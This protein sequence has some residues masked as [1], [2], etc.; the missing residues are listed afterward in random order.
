MIPRYE[1]PEIS[2]LWTEEHK[3]K[4]FLKVEL[5]LLEALES[6]KNINVER[7]NEIEMTTQHDLIA[8]CT[9]ITE[10]CPPEA[11]KYFHYGVTSSDIIDTSLSL[12]LKESIEQILPEY[13]ALQKV[14]WK[15]AN[16]FKKLICMGRSHGMFAE[17]QSFGQKFL[18]SYA[19]FA[20]HLELLKDFYENDCTGQLSGAVGNY[21]ILNTK[22]EEKA[23]K[24]LNLKIEPV[25]TQVIPRDRLAKFISISS[26]I[27]S[28]IERLSGEI[29]HLHHSDVQELHE[30]FSKGQK[31]S[32]TM[33]HKKN[34]ISAENLTGMARL[35]RSHLTIA[36]ENIA[37]W[38]ERDISHSST[39]RMYLPDHLGIL[40][41]SIRRLRKTID[42]LVIHEEAIEKKVA[43][44]FTYLS[45]YFLHH[46]IKNNE[47]MRETFYEIIQQAAFEAKSAQDFSESIVTFDKSKGITVSGL[48]KFDLNSIKEIYLAQIDNVFNRVQQTYPTP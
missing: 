47:G 34:P 7:I 28:A 41:Y 40:F 35:L 17:P 12:Q 4:T 42:S 1:C 18:T 2:H 43:H 16:E 26:L 14:L 32:S 9:S 48:P 24:K 11:A 39:E 27:A 45:S 15:R 44:N 6:E 33:P 25:T 23:L 5:A 10:K 29:R 46:L 13:Q 37:L 31:G 3:F 38:H 19:E 36:H 8:F 22:I 20:R 30:G 21:C